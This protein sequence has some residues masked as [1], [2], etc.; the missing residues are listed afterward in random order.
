MKAIRIHCLDNVAT[1]L[2]GL[3]PGDTVE[4]MERDGTSFALRVVELIPFGHKVALEAI[5]RGT[6]VLKYGASIGMATAQIQM[7]QHVH[8]HNLSS[9]RGKRPGG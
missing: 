1:V 4:I 7:G 5:D 6:D 9:K 2:G 8:V 3:R